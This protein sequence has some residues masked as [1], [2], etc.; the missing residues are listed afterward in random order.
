MPNLTTIGVTNGVPTSGSGTVST[1]DNMFGAAGSPSANVQS[2]QGVSGGTPLPVSASSLPLPPNAAQESGGNLATVA[3]AQGVGATGISQPAGGSGILGWLS[4][5]YGAITGTLAAALAA[6]SGAGGVASTFRIVSVAG[7][8]NASNVKAS[9]GRIYQIVGYN[10]ASALRYLKLYNKSGPPSVGTDTPFK[11]IPLP[12]MSAFVI[13]WSD[14][15]YYCAAGI[16]LGFTVN[17]ADADTTALTAGDIV[18]FSLD[19]A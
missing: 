4:G 5:I 16:S 15:G 13:D 12:P 18:G 1:I 10:A 7:T 3:S 6:A 19:Y 11:T 14:L 9:A 2:V 17:A 8:T